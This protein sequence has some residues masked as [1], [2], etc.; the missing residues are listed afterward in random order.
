MVKK[1]ESFKADKISIFTDTLKLI[2]K[3]V[4]GADEILN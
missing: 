4:K 2:G 3:A 1:I